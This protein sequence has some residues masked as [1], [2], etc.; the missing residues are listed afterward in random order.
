MTIFAK[1]K[2]ARESV[3][4]FSI[5]KE[6]IFFLVNAMSNLCSERD[7]VCPLTRNVKVSFKAKRCFQDLFQTNLAAV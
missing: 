1:Y 2:Q 4:S 6:T 7:T 3:S 5:F